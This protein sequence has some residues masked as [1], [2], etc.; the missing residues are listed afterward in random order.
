MWAVFKID[1]K[2]SN[3]FKKDEQRRKGKVIELNLRYELKNILKRIAVKKLG[4]INFSPNAFKSC[5]R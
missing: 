4:N 2:Y 5:S 1:Q 3:L